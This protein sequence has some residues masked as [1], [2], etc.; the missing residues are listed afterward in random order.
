MRSGI[1]EITSCEEQLLGLWI[2]LMYRAEMTI[3]MFTFIAISY[4]YIYIYIY[5]MFNL[6]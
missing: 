6:L 5:I 3:Y 1:H 2:L 4:T